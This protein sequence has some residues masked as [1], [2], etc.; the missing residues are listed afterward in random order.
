LDEDVKDGLKET[1]CFNM[2]YVV[3]GSHLVTGFCP[4]LVGPSAFNSRNSF[5]S[6]LLL[7]VSN[8]GCNNAV[9]HDLETLSDGNSP[10]LPHEMK[11]MKL[12]VSEVTNHH[13]LSLSLRR[14]LL[15]LTDLVSNPQY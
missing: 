8:S 14:R 15:P 12:V 9:V 1:G 3:T 2:D 13:H 11:A 10:F 6:L 7:I 4:D 5:V